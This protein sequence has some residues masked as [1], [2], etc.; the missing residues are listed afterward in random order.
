MLAVLG[1]PPDR[2]GLLA[3]DGVAAGLRRL[4]G[5]AVVGLIDDEQVEKAGEP[6]PV[7]QD[8]VE[9]ALH[10][11]RA[12]PLQA[13]DRARVDGEGVGLEAVGAAQL[14]EPVGVQD[15]ELQ[16]ELGLHL[17]LPLERERGGAD[18]D[19]PSGPVAEQHLLDDEAGLDR[20]AEAHVVGDEELHPGHAE[21]SRHRFELV[22]L[23]GD[24]GPERGLEG[25]GVGA[26][27][28]APADGV[29]EG[30]ESLGVVPVGARY[31]GE[32][33]LPSLR[34]CF[35]FARRPAARGRVESRSVGIRHIATQGVLK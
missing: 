2:C 20:L 23:D 21:R 6:R 13:D 31:L 14:P 26:G 11:G 33:E 29:Q 15:L 5:G 16:S 35:A 7:R 10:P 4:G 22:L 24:A 32:L 3:L 17:L 28:R 8:L 18:D 27:D 12:E 25:L 1:Q 9:H 19:D 34:F 30:A